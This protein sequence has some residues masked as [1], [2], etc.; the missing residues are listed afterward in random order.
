[1][2]YLKT[3]LITPCVILLSETTLKIICLKKV[4]IF[5]NIDVFESYKVNKAE[6]SNDGV[7]VSNGKFKIPGQLLVGADGANSFIKR[8]FLI[9]N[10][11]GKTIISLCKPTTK[12]WK[13][14]KT[15]L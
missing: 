1:M 13:M 14:L 11:T 3:D 12:D 10:P 15:M 4:K 9:S 7:F 5:E 8:E 2:I 6:V